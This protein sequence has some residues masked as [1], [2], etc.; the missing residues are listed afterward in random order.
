[1][2][3]EKKFDAKG[4]KNGNAKL[5]IRQ[6]IEIRHKYRLGYKQSSI[7]KDFDVSYGCINHI[8]LGATWTHISEDHLQNE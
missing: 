8:I 1:M 6:V 4:E 7:A 5:S 2:S 3:E